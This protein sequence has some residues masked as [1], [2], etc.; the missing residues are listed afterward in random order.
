MSTVASDSNTYVCQ[1]MNSDSQSPVSNSNIILRVNNQPIT[2]QAP[3]TIITPNLGD[4]VTLP[5][6]VESIPGVTLRY[7]WTKNGAQLGAANRM[8][9]SLVISS[10]REGLAD[11]GN[12]T[13]SV[14]LT[15]DGISSAP[16]IITIGSTILTAQGKSDTTPNVQQLL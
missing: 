6:A 11:S 2:D 15:V 9:G 16:L 4:D 8:T 12:Y 13:C 3:P 14:V 7:R 10:V 5:C 1:A